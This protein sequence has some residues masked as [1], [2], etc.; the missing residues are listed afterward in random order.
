[1]HGGVTEDL[2]AAAVHAATWAS[3]GACRHVP[4]SDEQRCSVSYCA[5]GLLGAEPDQRGGGVPREKKPFRPKAKPAAAEEGG[6][7][8]GSLA[9]RDRAAE[10]RDNANPDYEGVCWAASACP[11]G[12]RAL[13]ASLTTRCAGLAGSLGA[14]HASSSGFALGAPVAAALTVEETRYLGGDL[15]H[16][17]LVKGL[18]YALLHKARQAARLEDA[19]ERAEEARP[20]SDNAAAPPTVRTSL[21]RAIHAFIAGVCRMV[22]YPASKA[23]S[24]CE[25]GNTATPLPPSTALLKVA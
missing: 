17:H 10:R 1:M 7:G 21:G 6:G 19:G 16:T 20:S 4:S 11:A 9:Y 3:S 23:R 18:D 13:F 14:T 22:P 8:D 5:V 15:E 24:R 12:Q 2:R 25:Q